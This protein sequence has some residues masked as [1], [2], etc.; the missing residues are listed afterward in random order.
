MWDRKMQWRPT[1][2]TS[3]NGVLMMV[4]FPNQVSIQQNPGFISVQMIT[5]WSTLTTA[6]LKDNYT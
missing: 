6:L 4:K 5:P 3:I 1:Y 2:Y